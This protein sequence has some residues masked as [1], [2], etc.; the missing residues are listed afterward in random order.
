VGERREKRIEIN[1][2]KENGIKIVEEKHI[3]KCL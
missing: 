2:S 3:I 1:S